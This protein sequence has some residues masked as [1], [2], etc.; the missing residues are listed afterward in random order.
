MRFE[1]NSL[2]NALLGFIENKLFLKLKAQSP[3]TPDHVIRNII[4]REGRMHLAKEKLV[5]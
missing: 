5:K 4:K 3:S 1:N 2:Q